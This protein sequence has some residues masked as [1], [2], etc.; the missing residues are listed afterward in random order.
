MPFK[1]WWL[2]HHRTRRNTRRLSDYH[3]GPQTLGSNAWQRQSWCNNRN[4][5]NNKCKCVRLIPKPPPPQPSVQFSL[6][7]M[8]NFSWPHGPQHTRLPCPSPTPRVYS[9]SSPL[10]Q[11]CHLTISSSVNHLFSCLQSFPASRCFQMSQLFS[12]DG[13]SIGVSA[14]IS[15]LPLNTQDLL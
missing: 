12:S 8:S 14:S 9:N 1:Q 4:K 6:S 10:S 5:V 15:V 11:W 13:Q 7:V 3:K 2:D